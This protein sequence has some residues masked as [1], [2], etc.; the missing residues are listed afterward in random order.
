VVINADVTFHSL[1]SYQF[2]LHTFGSDST[3]LLLRLCDRVVFIFLIKL[4]LL[5]CK[6]LFSDI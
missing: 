3:G 4:H 5:I 1:F 6:K 2:Y